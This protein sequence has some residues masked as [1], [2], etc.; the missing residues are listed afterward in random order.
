MSKSLR[1]HELQNARLPCLSLSHGVFLNSCPL[2]HWC[3]PTILFSV[4]AF[5]SC[6]QSFPA[7]GSLPVSR[8]LMLNG[9]SIGASASISVLLMNIQSWFPLGL[10]GLISLQSKGFSRVFSNTKVWKHQFFCIQTSLW[11]NPH[12][13]TWLLEKPYLAYT[14]LCR[15]IDVPIFE[16]A[17]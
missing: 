4:T 11:S 15:Q 12:I 13:H 5:S 10:S 9:Q 1:P 6:P 2:S 14:K 7:L 16:Y 17:M 3:H 8:L